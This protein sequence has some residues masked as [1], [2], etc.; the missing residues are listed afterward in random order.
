V[1]NRLEQIGQSIVVT[2]DVPDRLIRLNVTNTCAREREE[3]TVSRIP[4][5]VCTAVTAAAGYRM[6]VRDIGHQLV[7]PNV[8]DEHGE[9]YGV[10][11]KGERRIVNGG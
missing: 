2:D 6:R 9:Q 5:P 3:L 11:R 7:P 4:R 10:R 1:S 8:P